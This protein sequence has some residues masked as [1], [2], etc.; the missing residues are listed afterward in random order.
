MLRLTW[1]CVLRASPA[2]EKDNNI[3][4][5]QLVDWLASRSVLTYNV[6]MDGTH[7]FVCTTSEYSR[8][9]K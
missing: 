6:Y 2:G 3:K 5:P 4:Y 7:T 8:E 1:F 9:V